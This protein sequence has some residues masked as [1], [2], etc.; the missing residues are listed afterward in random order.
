MNAF[1]ISATC[2]YATAY[3]TSLIAN[4]VLLST[5]AQRPKRHLNHLLTSIASSDLALT[6]LSTFDAIAFHKNSW[7]FGVE[8]C[9]IQS[10]LSETAYTASIITLTILS[11]KR[12]KTICNRWLSATSSSHHKILLTLTCLSAIVLQGPST[13]TYHIENKRCTNTRWGNQ[14]RLI[15]YI[16]HSICL[17]LLPLTIITTSHLMIIRF[18]FK[19]NTLTSRISYRSASDSSSSSIHVHHLQPQSKK[20][21]NKKLTRI[22]LTLSITFFL[23]WSPF[24]TIRILKYANIEIHPYIWPSS[25]ILL[26]INTAINPFIYGFYNNSPH[27]IYRKL[28][29]RFR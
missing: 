20:D 7:T 26:I 25:Q 22:L 11:F 10:G 8:L 12:Y 13:S 6:L 2:I 17:F 21:Q 9:I 16:I 28:Q 27:K 23:C 4:V 14:A 18:L 5:I 24:I 19:N 15:I 1:S 29:R 3:V